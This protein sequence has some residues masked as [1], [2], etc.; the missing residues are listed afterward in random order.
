MKS[1]VI[2]FSFI[3]NRK[4]FNNRRHF[5][6][7]HGIM[8]YPGGISIKYREFISIH[9]EP[10]DKLL[11]I[12]RELGEGKSSLKM[13]DPDKLH[14]TLKFLGDTDV[15]MNDDIVR[16]IENAVK[17]VAPFDMEIRDMGAFPS[18][19]YMK[20]IWLGIESNG[21][22]EKISESLSNDMRTLGF[23][24]DKGFKGHLTLARVRNARDK[25]KLSRII[26]GN[27]DEKV[28]AYHVECINLMKST[29]TPMGPIY[30]VLR[31][32]KIQGG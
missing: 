22:L 3:Y 25:K 2:I 20:V 9:V 6:H 1:A 16:I 8:K 26:S 12:H 11:A 10:N 27:R 13:V 7:Y 21:I 17:D 4:G 29:L 24:R 30:E 32:I 15:S 5:T 18:P 19:N 28:M 31:S 23:K 14:I